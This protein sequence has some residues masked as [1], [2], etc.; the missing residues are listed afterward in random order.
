VADTVDV[1]QGT[2]VAAYNVV[3]GFL[4]IQPYARRP[5]QIVIQGPARSTFKMYRGDR[6]TTSL[7]ISATPTGGGADNTYDSTT[8]GAPGLIGAGAQ[9]IGVWSGGVVGPGQT[10]VATMTS[11]VQA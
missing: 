11:V 4:P 1:I 6:P 8:D 7:Q 9:V 10:G 2:Y 3:M 5:T